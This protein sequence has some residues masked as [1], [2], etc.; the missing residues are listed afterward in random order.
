MG[1][2]P[3]TQNDPGNKKVFILYKKEKEKDINTPTQETYFF[4]DQRIQR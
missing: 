3:P 1:Q 4:L 2:T